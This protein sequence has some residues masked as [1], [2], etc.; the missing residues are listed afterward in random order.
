LNLLIGLTTSVKII[1]IPAKMST[2]S[3]PIIFRATI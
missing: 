3:F 2:S 1:Y